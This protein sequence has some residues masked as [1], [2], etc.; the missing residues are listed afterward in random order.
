MINFVSFDDGMSYINI[1]QITSFGIEE[2][3][4]NRLT[5]V[6]LS[7]GAKRYTSRPIGELA[8]MLGSVNAWY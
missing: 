2:R 5:V 3:E 8:E 4:G 7:D 1:S 6:H